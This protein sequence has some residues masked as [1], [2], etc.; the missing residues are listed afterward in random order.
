[1]AARAAGWPSG[2]AEA[3]P[4]RGGDAKPAHALRQ[5]RNSSMRLAVNAVKDG[6]AAA[7]VSPN[8]GALM[9]MAKFVLKTC[10]G[11]TARRLP[12]CCRRASGRW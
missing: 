11:W 3:H 8:T 1:M 12:R 2:R 6:E 10:R 5:N 4:G 7:A 9:A